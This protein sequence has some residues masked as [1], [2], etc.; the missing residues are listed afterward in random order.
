MK[1]ILTLLAVVFSTAYAGH[2]QN[3]KIK[4]ITDKKILRIEDST[5]NLLTHRTIIVINVAPKADSGFTKIKYYTQHDT[6]FTEYFYEKIDSVFALKR[7]NLQSS[8]YISFDYE[9]AYTKPGQKVYSH[10]KKEF[11][12]FSN[13]FLTKEVGTLDPWTLYN[14]KSKTFEFG[15][16]RNSTKT[17]PWIRLGLSIIILFLIGMVMVIDGMDTSIKNIRD[18]W[19]IIVALLVANMVFGFV[20]FIIFGSK[21]YPEKS[22]RLIVF[23][24]RMVLLFAVTFY[25]TRCR[26]KKSKELDKNEKIT[27]LD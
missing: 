3:A 14:P 1:N 7:H 19:G 13:Y 2:S 23:F 16:D 17:V 20:F 21:G 24:V 10:N 26:I 18:F 8:N 22:E 11:M 5:I 15:V 27:E 9:Q 4:S 6:S 25:Y 12:A